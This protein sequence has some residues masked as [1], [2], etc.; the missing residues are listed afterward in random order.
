MSPSLLSLHVVTI[1]IF[2]IKVVSVNKVVYSHSTKTNVVITFSSSCL[3]T[4]AGI[5][6]KER[7]AW[8]LM[9]KYL[10][11]GNL[12]QLQSRRNF[13]MWQVARNNRY[14]ALFLLYQ[15]FLESEIDIANDIPIISSYI[16]GI[17]NR[18]NQYTR[19]IKKMWQWASIDIFIFI[20]RQM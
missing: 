4:L 20:H 14:N 5:N 3:F 19:F 6:V 13:S 10:A 12:R 11:S 17:S 18:K 1:M 7:I 9:K 2:W 8:I 15:I 16:L